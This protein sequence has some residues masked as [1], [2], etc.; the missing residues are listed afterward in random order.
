[1]KSRIAIFLFLSLVFGAT[2]CSDKTP[3]KQADEGKVELKDISRDGAIESV[4]SVRHL[5]DDLDELK[6]AHRI[7]KDNQLVSEKIHLDTLPAL[8]V[9]QQQAVDSLGNS[10]KVNAKK[11]YEFYITVQ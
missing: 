11:D 5:S 8:S 10:V 4:L 2:A 6:T 1:M 7:W 9:G 3:E